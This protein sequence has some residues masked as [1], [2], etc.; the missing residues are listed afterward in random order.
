MVWGETKLT[1]FGEDHHQL[2]WKPFR[3]LLS[4]SDEKCWWVGSGN[5]ETIVFCFYLE[6]WTAFSFW[7][8][9]ISMMPFKLYTP[10]NWRVDLLE[11]ILYY[12][13]VIY[14]NICKLPSLFKSLILYFGVFLLK[15]ISI[16]FLRED[17]NLIACV[18]LC[19]IFD[20]LMLCILFF[21]VLFWDLYSVNSFFLFSFLD[22]VLY[23]SKFR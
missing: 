7:A 15:H 22:C 21:S 14:H 8:G 18:L 2:L 1:L 17:Y 19:V 16:L 5:W 20:L 6:V 11:I 10:V 13:M 4:D 3:R 23:F 9:Y 12:C